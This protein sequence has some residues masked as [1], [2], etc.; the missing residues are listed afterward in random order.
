MSDF[1]RFYQKFEYFL[2]DL[3]CKSCLFYKQKY[4][5]NKHGCGKNVCRFEDIR[6]NAITNGRIKREAGWFTCRE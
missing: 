6:Q 3:S 2:E 5:S 1:T 4:K